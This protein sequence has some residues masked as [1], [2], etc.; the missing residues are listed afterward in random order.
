MYYTVYK[1]TNKLNGKVYIGVHK[2]NDL[3]DE[4]LGSGKYLGRAIEKYG[5]DNF[6][7]EIL[8]VFDKSSEMF[9]MESELVNEEFVKRDDTYN[10][11]EGGHGG[12]DHLNDGSKEHIDR[13]KQGRINANKNGA[14]ELAQ[15]VL[16]ELRK[17][18]EW[19]E[20]KRKKTVESVR[21]YYK[22]HNGWAKG[23]V[24]SEE[25]KQKIGEANSKHQKG[26]GNSQ[27]GTMWIMNLELKQCKKIKKTDS[28]PDGWV[29]GRKYKF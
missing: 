29:K 17:N 24:K 3:H 22:T 11:K 5:I 18:S 21:K 15:D 26:K 19:V 28:I 9:E 2:T 13:T 27:Y 6:E 10:L 7:K 20:S 1:T 25:H 8:A 4:Y 12:W 14:L 16:I 23:T